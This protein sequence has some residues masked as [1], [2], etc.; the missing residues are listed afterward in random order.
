[1]TW[2]KGY[3]WFEDRLWS[4]L[5]A[6]LTRLPMSAAFAWHDDV[7]DARI[8]CAGNE[9]GDLIQVQCRL[10]GELDFT[11]IASQAEA[12]AALASEPPF[13]III[14]D[15]RLSRLGGRA[16]IEKLRRH[17]PDAERLII[18]RRLDQAVREMM[19]NDGRVMRLLHAPLPA[20]V[21]CGAVADALL[22]HRARAL[23]AS[24]APRVTP[25]GGM[26]CCTSLAAM[27]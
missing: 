21:L 19:E 22:R 24:A 26:P 4:G 8:L 23:R 15:Q 14:V 7:A 3:P 5:K 13:D 17:S 1:M 25:M 2:D 27:A 6:T 16:F 20:D 9:L 12:D 10:E 11:I 18:V